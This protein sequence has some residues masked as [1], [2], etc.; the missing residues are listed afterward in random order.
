MSIGGGWV[1]T[2]AMRLLDITVPFPF[3]VLVL[4]IGAVLGPGIE[5][6]FIAL[7]QEADP[8]DARVQVFRVSLCHA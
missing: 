1:D 3:F 4:A 8:S 7:D 5:I 2:L 6:Y